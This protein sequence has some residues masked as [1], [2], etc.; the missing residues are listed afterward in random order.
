MIKSDWET[1]YPVLGI[2]NVDFKAMPKSWFFLS[3]LA[4]TCENVQSSK[5][6]ILETKLC[7]KIKLNIIIISKI[8]L[9]VYNTWQS[10]SSKFWD[11]FIYNSKL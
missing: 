11:Q 1:L 2:R 3:N 10:R 4:H 8:T 9:N 6:I 5:S 7:L